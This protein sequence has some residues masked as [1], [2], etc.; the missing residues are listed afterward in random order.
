MTAEGLNKELVRRFPALLP[1]YLEIKRLWGGAEP[2]PHI[3]YGDALVP[4]IRT[5][6]AE[7]SADNN[8][9]AIMTFLEELSERADSDA[10]DVLVTSVLEPLLDDEHR[11][12]FEQHLGPRTR[13]LW[14]RLKADIG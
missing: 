11:W 8:L 7:K 12:R 9:L 1:S 5:T 6:L 14:A 2:G 3:V 10:L 13:R 4:L